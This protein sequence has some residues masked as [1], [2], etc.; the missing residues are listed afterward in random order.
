MA[1]KSD[2]DFE[3]FV[4]SLKSTNDALVK[5]PLFQDDFAAGRKHID[6]GNII[7]NTYPIQ[8]SRFPF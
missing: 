7:M 4:T 5:S 1:Q 2:D 6:S 8:E 3:R